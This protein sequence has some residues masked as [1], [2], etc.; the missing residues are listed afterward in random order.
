[1]YSLLAALLFSALVTD[2]TQL[3][4]WDGERVRQVTSAQSREEKLALLQQLNEKSLARRMSDAQIQGLYTGIGSMVLLE[5]TGLW[6]DAHPTYEIIFRKQERVRG[7]WNEVPDRMLVR[8]REKPRAVYAQWLEGGRHV[9]Q[10]I[11]YDERKDPQKMRA[12]AGGLLNLITVNVGVHSTLARRE[13][14]HDLG[15]MGFRRVVA[16]LHEDRAKLVS[17]GKPIE[18]VLARSTVFE[19]E[20]F[21]ENTFVTAGPPQFYA[22]KAHL[23]F[24]LDTGVPRLV[25]IFDAK[26]EI[27]ERYYYEKVRWVTLD[28]HAFDEENPEY[29]F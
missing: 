22:A 14:N 26:G 6:L 19:G 28:D 11:L 8:Y 23:F 7:E 18:P 1:M 24:D 21:W 12:H 25:E 20:R 15:E 17:A 10:E 9:G 3:L 27:Q 13:S 16:S 5:A 4:S 29:D 2:A